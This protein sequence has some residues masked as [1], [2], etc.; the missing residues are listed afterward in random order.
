MDREEFKT[1]LRRK[2]YSYEE[3]G[4]DL[5]VTYGGPNGVFLSRLESI[6]PNIK[7]TNPGYVDLSFLED[8]P[9]GISFKNKG[10]VFLTLVERIPGGTV[11]LNQEDVILEDLKKIEGEVI[12]SNGGKVW[13]DSIGVQG[14]SK[15]VRFK[16]FD[17]ISPRTKFENLEIRGISPS[18]ILNSLIEQ[19]YG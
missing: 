5:V 8:L 3:E 4:K 17:R 19:I 9:E 10:S 7:F 14:F 2:G 11:F 6:P 15:G 1:I 13:L 16:N 12:F 18:R